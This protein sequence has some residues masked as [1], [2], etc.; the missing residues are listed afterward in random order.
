MFLKKHISIKNAFKKITKDQKYIKSKKPK[1]TCKI[2]KI[3][4]KAKKTHKNKKKP[5][6]KLKIR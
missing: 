2:K 1:N 3:R 4:E 5:N 6:K